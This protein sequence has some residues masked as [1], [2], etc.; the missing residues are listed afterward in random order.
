[1]RTALA[2][3]AILWS[4]AS[5]ADEPADLAKVRAYLGKK[6]PGRKWDSGP[7]RIDS[8]ALRATYPAL[9]FYYVFSGGPLPP[10]AVSEESER[11]FR[12][13]ADAAAKKLSMMVSIDAKG[14][15]RPVD[16]VEQL[17]FRL[18]RP[19]TEEERHRAA[20]AIGSLRH[21]SL[22]APT[23][24]DPASV[25]PVGGQE[26]VYNAIAPGQVVVSVAFDEAGRCRFANAASNAPMPPS[27]ARPPVLP[28]H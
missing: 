22:A 28:P 20:A 8:P 23:V 5:R 27:T 18:V 24:L 16:S 7:A 2:L 15:V 1:M 26:G 6:E 21:A 9:R 11:R 14:T 25:V 3:H 10:G 13:A 19:K 4:G 12:E 17:N